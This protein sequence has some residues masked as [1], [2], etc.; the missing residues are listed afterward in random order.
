[1]PLKVSTTSPTHDI[2]LTIDDEPV[3]AQIKRLSKDEGF[4]FFREFTRL[5][6]QRGNG[7]V[8]D[9]ELTR[10]EQAA[11]TFI[12]SS[13]VANVAF[14]AGDCIGDEGPIVTGAQIVEAFRFRVDVM[15]A[16]YQA[17]YSENFLGKAQKK[18]LNSRHIFSPGSKLPTA[19]PNGSKPD[20]TA[21][22]VESASTAPAAAATESSEKSI[23]GE[24]PGKVH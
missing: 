3:R 6:R 9:E 4:A 8:S 2:T 10:R 5:G 16:C 1:M 19:P 22:S 24:V 17:I 7:E 21:A 13:I 23:S 20:S 18:I 15:G 11:Q 12:E 14:E